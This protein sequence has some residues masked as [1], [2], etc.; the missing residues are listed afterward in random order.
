MTVSTRKNSMVLHFRAPTCELGPK[1]KP[2]GEQHQRASKAGEGVT[3]CPC[4]VQVEQQV[5]VQVEVQVEQQVESRQR[6]RLQA[7]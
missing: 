5:E 7:R 2:A 6:A 4:R 3:R 1:K